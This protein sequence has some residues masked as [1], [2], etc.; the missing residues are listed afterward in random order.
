[1][2]N[3]AN[4]YGRFNLSF[5]YGKGCWLYS[6]EKGKYLDMVAG[7]AVCCLGHSHEKFNN[8]LKTQIDKVLHVSNL[9]KIEPQEVLAKKLSEK[10]FADKVFFCNSGTEAN[11]AAIKLTRKYGLEK[12][13][14]KKKII[15]CINSFHGRTTGSL[16]IT[17]QEKH[18]KGFGEL[19]PDIE[20]IEFNNTEQLRKAMNH[21][22]AGV[23]A[24]VIQGEG[25]INKIDIDFLVE[26]RNLCDKFDSAL[27]FD[28]VQ[29]GIGRTGKLFAY[30]NF[31]IAPDLMTIAKGLGNGIPIGALLGREKFMQ[32][33][34]PGTHAATFGG[35]YLSTTAGIAVLDIIEEEN[36]LQNVNICGDYFYN[37]L[38]T[39]QSLY[40]IIK[41]VKGKGLM[42]GIDVGSKQQEIIKK[43]IE[44][45]LLVVGAGASVIRLVPPLIISKNEIDICC[46]II[47]E[48]LK[49]L[50]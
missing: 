32:T 3:V 30:E 39:L 22:V 20:F 7:I 5:D 35:N 34:S 4:T 38:K 45:K 9:Y 24:E 19:L 17:G 31:Q 29:T 12:S 46:N 23:F 41:E 10:S 15:S 26:L 33:F 49:E 1:M 14:N 25:G 8:R 2:S 16:S 48:T 11:E 43:V 27:V 13:Q 44:K 28:E 21:D 36:I 37:R 6:Q 50:Q 40:P 47:E 42:L 18:K